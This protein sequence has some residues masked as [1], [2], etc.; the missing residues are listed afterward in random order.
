MKNLTKFAMFAVVAAMCL[1]C[2]NDGRQKCRRKK[3]PRKCKS[4]TA[5]VVTPEQT[6]K[7]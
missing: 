4:C 5:F 7:L 1:S 2:G 3:S 6:N